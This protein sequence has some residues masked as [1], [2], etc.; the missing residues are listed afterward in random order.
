MTSD[1]NVRLNLFQ[2]P[3]QDRLDRIALT[4]GS[5]VIFSLRRRARK[6]SLNVQTFHR[7][8]PFSC[9]VDE[10]KTV[11]LKSVNKK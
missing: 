7:C 3:G 5:I 2:T 6:S 10:K 9:T 4:C 11:L 1:L 8:I